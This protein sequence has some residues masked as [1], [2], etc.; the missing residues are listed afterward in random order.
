MLKSSIAISHL[1]KA[2]FKKVFVDDVSSKV[3][4][5]T[6]KIYDEYQSALALNGWRVMNFSI[7]FISHCIS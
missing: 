6:V 2:D 3:E 5:Y 1:T 7:L 4:Q